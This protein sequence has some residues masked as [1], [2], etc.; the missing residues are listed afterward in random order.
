[1]FCSAI[2]FGSV[3]VLFKEE[4]TVRK[5]LSRPLQIRKRLLGVKGSKF[6]RVDMIKKC[7]AKCIQ[8]FVLLVR[9]RRGGRGSPLL[10]VEVPPWSW[11]S[12]VAVGGSG[13]GMTGAV[14]IINYFQDEKCN[15]NCNQFRN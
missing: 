6:T 5:G 10:V 15:C 3:S 7:L 13:A 14:I 12:L 9:G 11:K 4:R 2:C 1:M 8:F